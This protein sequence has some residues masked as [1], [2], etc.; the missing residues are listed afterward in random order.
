MS[1]ALPTPAARRAALPALLLAAA[2][3]LAAP[4]AGAD[5]HGDAAAR[6]HELWKEAAGLH[7]EGDYE[8]AIGLYRRALEI[9]ATAR[10]HNYLG[11][12]LS[13][14]GRYAEA[15]K[16]SRAAIALDPD[17]PNAYN[18]LGAYLIEQG[19]PVEAEPW[20]REATRMDGYCC[21]HFAYYQL[22]RS[23]LLQSRI[24]EAR[25]ALQTALMIHPSYQPA[26]RLL[27]EMRERGLQGS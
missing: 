3:A 10:I 18:D 11:W 22:G 17:Y 2:L 14:L 5:E 1:L 25:G 20:L 7:I 12:S 23:L 4:P 9:H 13:E 24:G 27:A 6:A 8:A 16:H 15:A 19:K 26:I 21:T